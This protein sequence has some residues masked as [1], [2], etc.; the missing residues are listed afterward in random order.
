[1]SATPLTAEEELGA[2]QLASYLDAIQ[3]MMPAGEFCITL[4]ARHTTDM[5]QS[6]TM[7]NDD[8]FPEITRVVQIAANRH[9]L[10]VTRQGQC[11]PEDV[12]K[13]PA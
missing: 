3:A 5:K 10:F 7:G 6:F 13:K 12:E 4:V 9:A 11:K 8:D 1:M 2:R